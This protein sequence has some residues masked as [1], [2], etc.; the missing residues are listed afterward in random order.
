MEFNSHTFTRPFC[1]IYSA[2]PSPQCP[3]LYLQTMASDNKPQMMR[4]SPTER[5]RA[6]GPLAPESLQDM[7]AKLQAGR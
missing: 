5:F 6:A 2:S 7:C 1:S 3:K 4:S